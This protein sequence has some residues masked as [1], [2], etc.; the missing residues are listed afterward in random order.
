MV[1]H[2]KKSPEQVAQRQREAA[3]L[4][5]AAF[6]FTQAA[7]A[8]ALDANTVVAHA[9]L[10]KPW[11]SSETIEKGEIRLDIETGQ[12]FRCTEPIIINPRTK[13]V[14]KPPSEDAVKWEAIG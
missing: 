8:G 1:I 7:E 10:F 5:A 14:A 13:A 4:S 9:A 3:A 12:L 11:D 2:R 6:M